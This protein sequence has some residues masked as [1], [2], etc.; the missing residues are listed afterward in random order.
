MKVLLLCYRGN[1]YCGGQGIYIYHLSKELA[2]LGVEVDIAAG[3]PYPDPVDD[4]ANLY[5]IENLN[6]WSVKTGHFS[7][8]KLKRIFNPLN[9]VDYILTRFHV[10]SE[11]ETFSMRVFHL[12][13]KILKKKRYDLIHDVNSLGWG[14]IPMKGFG[15][16]IIT[17]IHHPLTQDRNADLMMDSSFWEKSATILFYPLNMQKC[18]I[19]KLDR[20]ITSSIEGVEELNN[21]FSL[22]KEKVSVVFNG[23]DTDVFQRVDVPREKDTLLF[24]GNTED[25]KKGIVYLLQALKMLP[26][27][28]KLTIVDEGPPL[29]LT[30]T[31]LVKSIGVEDRVEFTGKVSIDKLVR[32]YSSKSILVMSSL[33]EGFGLPAAEAMSCETPVVVTTS[34]ALKEV[35]TPDCGILVP[36][37]DP[38]AMKNAIE[39]LLND[40]NLRK[41]MG[42]NGRKRAVEKFS[43]SIAAKNTLDVYENVIKNYR[44]GK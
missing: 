39:K 44:R 1:P 14:L 5:K 21:A 24:V 41:E 35:V 25:H 18:V 40:D 34:G 12:L 27:H 13:K 28:I 38:A 33:H 16:P 30:A 20:T 32:F 19:N 37:R 3:P 26:D 43:W 31:K 9:F 42:K 8:D 36:P 7:Y 29:K 23:M 17:T 22:K 15:I 2:K 11:M 4:W 10:F 6:M